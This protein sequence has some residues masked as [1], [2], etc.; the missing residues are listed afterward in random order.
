MHELVPS[1]ISRLN[2]AAASVAPSIITKA[3]TLAASE[4]DT[5]PDDTLTYLPV[6]LTVG[7]RLIC[8]GFDNKIDCSSSLPSIELSGIGATLLKR[9]CR[10]LQSDKD[11]FRCLTIVG[12]C[13]VALTYLL[14]LLHVFFMPEH[15]SWSRVALSIGIAFFVG[16]SSVVIYVMVKEWIYQEIL[17][18]TKSH[19]FISLT[20]QG[21]LLLLNIAVI[22][23]I[24]LL[25][26]LG[27]SAYYSHSAKR[28]SQ[29]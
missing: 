9:I 11:T 3:E 4:L 2:V 8:L 19:T 21:D 16:V 29:L 12:T 22:C 15:A 18:L 1:R 26:L 7:T 25:V 24:C 23:A 5:D 27:L 6:N 17:D 20:A 14:V 28:R 13:L 10:E